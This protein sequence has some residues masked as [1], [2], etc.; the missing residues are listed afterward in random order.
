[1]D[2]DDRPRIRSDAAA[3]LARESLDTYSR[4]ELDQRVALLEAEIIRVRT[5]RGQADSSRAAA[6]ALFGNKPG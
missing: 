3:A 1:M 5:A 2:D 4:D 6:E